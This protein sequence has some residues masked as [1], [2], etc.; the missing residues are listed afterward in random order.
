MK[1]KLAVIYKKNAYTIFKKTVNTSET[2]GIFLL[3][4]VPS[5]LLVLVPQVKK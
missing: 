5:F 4:L 3:A 1:F 2:N